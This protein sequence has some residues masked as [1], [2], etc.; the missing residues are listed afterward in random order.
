MSEFNPLAVREPS[1]SDKEERP[2]ND[3]G[4]DLL[5]YIERVERLEDDKAEIAED[6]KG[7]KAE[8]KARGYD[9][10]VV[11]EMLKL[12]KMDKDTRDQFESVRDT[13][14]HA[15]GIFG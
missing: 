9:M 2:N 14:G 11:G 1:T 5:S 12:R 6:I 4:K 13:Y 8:M 10:K 7:V 15:L 3:T